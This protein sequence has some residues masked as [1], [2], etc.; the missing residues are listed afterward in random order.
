MSRVALVTGGTRGIGAEISI[1]LKEKGYRVAATYSGNH[2]AA[3][4]F[5]K[6]ND[7]SV[8]CWDVSNSKACDEGVSHV[9]DALGPIEI[10]VNNA[11]ITRDRAFRKMSDDD[12]H[13]VMNT[14]LSSVFYMCRAVIESMRAAGFGRII[15]I[16]SINGQRGRY[17][18]ANY[19]AAKAG[20]YGLTK[21]LAM[22]Y[23]RRGIT[24]NAIAPGHIDTDI[25]RSSSPELIESLVAEIPIGRLG[26]P[27]D[28]ARCVTFLASEDAEFITGS[29]LTVNG[30][31]YLT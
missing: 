2:S 27:Q 9:Q 16:S 4:A 23:A 24:V 21:A 31:T 30:G 26:T 19:S 14:N 20:I 5:N 3:E 29:T 10:L 8:F 12:W 22:E 15:N 18:Q 6:A 28:I 7:I 1:A 13:T 25:V 11:G 17:G